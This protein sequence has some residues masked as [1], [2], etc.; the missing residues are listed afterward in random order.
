MAE[1]RDQD[2]EALSWDRCREAFHVDGSL[3]DIYVLST[4]TGDWDRL[5]GLVRSSTWDFSYVA[6]ASSEQLPEASQQVF[7]DLDRAKNL[8][9]DL[10]FIQVNCHF[11]TPEEIELDI[12]P[13]EIQSQ[14]AMDR[15]LSFTLRLGH[16]LAKEVVIT[17]EN[18]PDWVWFRYEPASEV[19]TFS[20]PGGDR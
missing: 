7:E 1:H 9:I 5:L 19:I 11:F 15:V 17:E 12:D 13:R 6:D 3:R 20:A 16:C 2:G 18:S 14:E 8:S 10:G 4:D